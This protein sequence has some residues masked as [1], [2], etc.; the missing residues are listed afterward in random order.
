MQ[1]TA[2]TGP[3][4]LQPPANKTDTLAA[5]LVLSCLSWVV[6]HE[7]RIACEGYL[8]ICFFH[9]CLPSHYLSV[10]MSVSVLYVATQSPTEPTLLIPSP[11]FRSYWWAP[12]LTSMRC[13]ESRSKGLF[14]LSTT[15]SLRV[16]IQSSP[17]LWPLSGP[18]CQA[19]ASYS[20]N[21][22]WA[23]CL[24]FGPSYPFFFFSGSPSKSKPPPLTIVA[25]Y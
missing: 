8:C 14:T 17:V 24:F 3:R 15:A 1:L 9:L 12:D 18:W 22:R 4:W 2:S 5:L 25:C 6:P 7:K 23:S 10:S 20:T 21:R 13:H 19:S 11:H 16:Q